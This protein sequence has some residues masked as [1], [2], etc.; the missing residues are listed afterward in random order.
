[1]C[2]PGKIVS[3]IVITAWR[4]MGTGLIK[5]EKVYVVR[6]VNVESLRCLPE[7]DM[8]ACVNYLIKNSLGPAFTPGFPTPAACAAAASEVGMGLLLL[9]A[10]HALQ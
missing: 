1:M 2:S 5:V 9:L 8:I 7:A 4:Q 6:H 10:P 3:I